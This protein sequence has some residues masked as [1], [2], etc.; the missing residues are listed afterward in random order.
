MLEF[1]VGKA[2]YGLIAAGFVPLGIVAPAGRCASRCVASWGRGSGDLKAGICA[3]I[4]AARLLRD[5]GVP[6][7]GEI[8]F[9]FVGDERHFA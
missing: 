4:S 9:A 2:L 7:A 5:A 6:L 1:E 3:A 8:L